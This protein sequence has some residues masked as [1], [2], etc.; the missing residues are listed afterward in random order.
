[1]N[2]EEGKIKSTSEFAC[3]SEHLDKHYKFAF[4]GRFNENTELFYNLK[5]F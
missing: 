1:M 3:L 2:R 4:W 5:S